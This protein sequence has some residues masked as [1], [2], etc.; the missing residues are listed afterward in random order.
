[1]VGKW[2]AFVLKKKGFGMLGR[3]SGLRLP[4]GCQERE[5]KGGSAKVVNSRLENALL[6]KACLQD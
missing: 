3:D 2:G 6:R 4:S 1:M 5:V